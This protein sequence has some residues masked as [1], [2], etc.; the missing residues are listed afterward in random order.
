MD[1]LSRCGQLMSFV[2]HD[3]VDADSGSDSYVFAAGLFF[4]L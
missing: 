2:F 1:P 3:E 4:N